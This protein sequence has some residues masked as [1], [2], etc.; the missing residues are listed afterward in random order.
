MGEGGRESHRDCNL[1]GMRKRKKGTRG[2]DSGVSKE[3]RERCLALQGKQTSRVGR[4][5]AT[6]LAHYIGRGRVAQLQ[7]NNGHF[8]LARLAATAFSG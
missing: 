1:G 8:Q 7:P 2:R 4:D 5:P 6:N 3:S